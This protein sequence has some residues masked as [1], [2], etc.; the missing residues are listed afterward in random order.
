MKDAVDSR[1]WLAP[2]TETSF[3][4]DADNTGLEP[5]NGMP[6][7]CRW[8]GYSQKYIMGLLREHPFQGHLHPLVS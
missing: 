7:A 6:N 3:E 5:E 1:A 4:H 8:C 2:R